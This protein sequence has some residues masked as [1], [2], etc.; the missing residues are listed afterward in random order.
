MPSTTANATLSFLV[1]D[2]PAHTLDLTSSADI[3]GVSRQSVQRHAR[4]VG[5]CFRFRFKPARRITDGRVRHAQTSVQPRSSAKTPENRNGYGIHSRRTGDRPGM[6]EV[7]ERGSG[8]FHSP[9][10]VHSSFGG[11]KL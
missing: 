6:L 3:I 11:F 7:D 5:V 2:L 1:S 8:V 10:V 4:D 9:G